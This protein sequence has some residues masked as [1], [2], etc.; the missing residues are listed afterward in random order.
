MSK[1]IMQQAL[2]VLKDWDALIKFQY[3]GSSEAM[4]AMQ[5]VAWN[6][7]DIIASLE[8]ELAKLEQAE[9]DKLTV[10]FGQKAKE[11][12]ET[13]KKSWQPEQEIIHMNT[14]TQLSGAKNPWVG[15][16]DEEM[17]KTFYETWSFDPYEIA[18]A[19]E[20]KLKDKNHATHT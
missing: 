20:A 3:S 14:G 1:E 13:A 11:Y 15:L 16:T 5:I 7:V 17:K 4:S 9:Y 10:K 18:R 2:T 12:L 19:I 8:T 6:T